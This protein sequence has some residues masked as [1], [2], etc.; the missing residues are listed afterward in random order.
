MPRYPAHQQQ[1][2][3]RSELSLYLKGTLH[4]TLKPK[5]KICARVFLLFMV[6]LRVCWLC[7]LR[8]LLVQVKLARDCRCDIGDIFILKVKS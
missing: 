7:W 4:M 6:L 8:V 1:L 2:G 3:L 5:C